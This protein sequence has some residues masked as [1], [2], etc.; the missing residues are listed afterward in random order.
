MVSLLASTNR[1]SYGIPLD[2]SD[3][4]ASLPPGG[5]LDFSLYGEFPSNTESS[6]YF[7]GVKLTCPND[8]NEANNILWSDEAVEYERGF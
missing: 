5:S 3:R 6:G 1:D 7:I 4:Y 8:T 2:D